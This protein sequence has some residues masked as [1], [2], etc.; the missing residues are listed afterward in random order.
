MF[1]TKPFLNKTLLLK[2]AEQSLTLIFEFGW[3]NEQI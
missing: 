1:V 2:K 3:K